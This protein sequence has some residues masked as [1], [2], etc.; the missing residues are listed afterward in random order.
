M[1]AFRL[2]HLVLQAIR[3]YGYNEDAM[4]SACGISIEGQLTP[5]DGR[6]LNAPTVI[7]LSSAFFFFPYCFHL[8]YFV[9][10]NLLLSFIKLSLLQLKVGNSEDCVPRNGRWNYN[11]KVIY[12]ILFAFLYLSLCYI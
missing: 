5:V 9:T 12:F 10:L 6:V 3:N 8:M 7:S 4:L 2:M 11:N 1:Y